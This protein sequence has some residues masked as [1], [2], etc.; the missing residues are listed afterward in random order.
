MTGRDEI[1]FLVGILR[2]FSLFFFLLGTLGLGCGCVQARGE[3]A[4]L[5]TTCHRIGGN[6]TICHSLDMTI[7]DLSH[8]VYD[9]WVL[10]CL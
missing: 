6:L 5:A 2:F 10:M 1:G 8:R 4:V 3:V 7:N 9:M